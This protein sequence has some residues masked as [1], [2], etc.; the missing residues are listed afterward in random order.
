MRGVLVFQQCGIK[1][2]LKMGL[3]LEPQEDEDLN[4]P[5][6]AKENLLLF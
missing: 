6:W 1:M 3:T 4:K 2:G 5:G